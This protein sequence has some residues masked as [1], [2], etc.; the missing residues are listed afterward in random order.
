MIALD[1]AILFP[2]VTTTDLSQRVATRKALS[3]CM[4]RYYR[5]TSIRT[6][7][8]KGSASPEQLSQTKL[9]GRMKCFR[10]RLRLRDYLAQHAKNVTATLVRPD[11]VLP[12]HFN[13]HQDI[14]S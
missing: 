5:Q 4:C 7:E 1:I 3:K 6:L 13:G 8:V 14:A 12:G 9:V 2:H 11:T 10:L